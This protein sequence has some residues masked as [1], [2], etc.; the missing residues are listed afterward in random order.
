MTIR[1]ST[2]L[3]AALLIAASIC[4]EHISAGEFATKEEAIAMVKKA[5]ALINEQGPDKAYKQFSSKGGPFHDRDL[6]I[7]VLD[8]DGKVLAHGQREDLIGKVLVDLKDP[9]GEL[10]IKERIELARQQSSFW[11]NYKFMNP[12]TKQVEPKQMYCERL[13]QTMVCGGV[14]SF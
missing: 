10:F 9:D 4:G 11:Q 2:L 1:L 13:N 14:Y 3:S 12:V 7:T 6:Y 5:A 8:L